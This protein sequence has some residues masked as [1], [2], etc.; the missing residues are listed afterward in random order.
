MTALV[1]KQVRQVTVRWRD[2]R[3]GP[4]RLGRGRRFEQ[5]QRLARSTGSITDD[6]DDDD[7]EDEQ[8]AASP[9]AFHLL[10][11]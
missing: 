5:S 8:V 7:D 2:F 6:D 1:D 10:W 3:G 11:T 4:A 9:Q